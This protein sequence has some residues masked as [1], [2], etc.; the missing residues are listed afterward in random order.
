MK[1]FSFSL[2]LAVLIAL[3]ACIVTADRV[4]EERAS[5]IAQ[6]ILGKNTES[7]C[8]V[9]RFELPVTA[10]QTPQNDL[11]YYIFK[12]DEGFA[13]ISAEDCVPPVLGYS[14]DHTIEGEIPC[15]MKMWLEATEQ[16]INNAKGYEP[17]PDI[18]DQWIVGD[19]NVGR[20]IVVIQTAEWNQGYPYNMYC[21]TIDGSNC[22][23]GCVA[24]AHAIVMYHHQWPKQGFGRTTKYTSS[25]GAV[26]NSRNLNHTYNW[27]KM[28]MNNLTD[29][30]PI[31]TK[32]AVATLMAD[33]GAAL[34][35][36]YGLSETGA[37]F[38]SN[39]TKRLFNYQGR[40]A[41]EYQT[42]YSTWMSDIIMQL[43]YNNPVI[44]AKGGHEF[45][46]D[47]YTDQDYFHINWG[48]GG[49]SN[50]YFRLTNLL[51]FNQGSAVCLL[52]FEPDYSMA[53]EDYWTVYSEQDDRG[54]PSLKMAIDLA[55]RNESY[56]IKL[57]ESQEVDPFCY[58]DG[59][60]TIDLNGKD[61]IFSQED[62]YF[63]YPW[64]GV[65]T[66]TDGS[67]KR[68]GTVTNGMFYTP[69][70]SIL[71]VM[72]G[73]YKDC[74]FDVR[75]GCLI[76]GVRAESDSRNLLSIAEGAEV[77]IESCVFIGSEG[78]L[79]E[80][81]CG[82][83]TI[84]NS[85]LENNNET[86]TALYCYGEH[87]TCLDHVMIKS[88]TWPIYAQ[89]NPIDCIY[90]LFST[91]PGSEFFSQDCS[92]SSNTDSVTKGIYPYVVS[93]GDL[94]SM[95]QAPWTPETKPKEYISLSGHK[96]PTPHPGINII[97]GQKVLIGK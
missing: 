25:L 27:D 22:L 70:N 65:L 87:G 91:R 2:L 81:Y 95:P 8:K 19:G 66:I 63:A 58:N 55:P 12:S 9:R 83:L 14:Q 1:T 15:G 26:V 64:N 67:D 88:P 21:P 72:G 77:E 32:Q 69:E 59:D 53:Y 60:L 17:S 78:N 54:Y 86:T 75:G 73:K 48:W 11:P 36:N 16:Y 5:L 74:S 38:S 50:G 89:D 35:A 52:D 29:K 37:D 51:N 92:I 10:E 7:S 85:S 28:A 20:P 93:N 57:L 18:K 79:I 44:Y 94:T 41:Y 68:T 46:V 71:Y 6:K 42:N 47:G 30:D 80:N 56:T 13:I 33:I 31:E 4:D 24:T 62:P 39:S 40:Y 84:T 90:G 96:S 76:K 43:N 97:N 61:L 34:K 23:T 45:I 82:Y 49:S 3:P